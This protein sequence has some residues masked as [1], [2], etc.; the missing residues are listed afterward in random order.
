M[1][2]RSVDCVRDRP[3]D[4]NWI[5]GWHMDW[6]WFVDR[7]GHCVWHG[8]W[9]VMGYWHWVWGGHWLGMSVD[10]VH[11]LGD[12]NNGAGCWCGSGGSGVS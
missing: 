12:W 9:Y 6:V 2:N 7:V 5:R 11:F 4:W 1:G 3:F 8:Y 10:D